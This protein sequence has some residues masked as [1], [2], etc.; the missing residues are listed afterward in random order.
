MF[1]LKKNKIFNVLKHIFFSLHLQLFCGLIQ[2][3]RI[4]YLIMLT[5]KFIKNAKFDLYYK[6]NLNLLGLIW[7]L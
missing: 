5:I 1:Q 6:R 3:K 2:I 7:Q 4:V